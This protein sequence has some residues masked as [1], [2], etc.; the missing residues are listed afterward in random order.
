MSKN[1]PNQLLTSETTD[2]SQLSYSNH[3]GKVQIKYT[4]FIFKISK[5]NVHSC[6]VVI[7]N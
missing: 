3:Q 6:T 7:T 4:L 2:V 5:Y 1:V